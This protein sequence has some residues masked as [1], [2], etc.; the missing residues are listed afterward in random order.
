MNYKKY[1]TLNICIIIIS[2]LINKLVHIH[3]YLNG[4]VIYVKHIQ[5]SIY[6]VSILCIFVYIPI[7]LKNKFIALIKCD[8]WL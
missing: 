1:V 3:T 4:D 5:L 8:S 2:I 7:N 6:Y